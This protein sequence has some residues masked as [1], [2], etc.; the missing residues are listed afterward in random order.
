MSLDSCRMMT[1]TD[2]G[3]VILYIRPLQVEDTSAKM[4]IRRLTSDSA[5][6]VIWRVVE[7]RALQWMPT[8]R[9]SI[10]FGDYLTG[11]R[12]LSRRAYSIL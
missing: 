11:S 1:Y 7:V 9:C 2:M 5:E 10:S 6:N 12:R 3:F 4:V 8:Q